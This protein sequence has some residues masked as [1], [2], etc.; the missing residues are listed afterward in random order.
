MANRRGRPST[1]VTS[2][3]SEGRRWS[4]GCV[5]GPKRKGW[6]CARALCWTAPVGPHRVDIARGGA[7]IG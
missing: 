3:R 6:R 7:C 4:T 2:V 5:A 1:R